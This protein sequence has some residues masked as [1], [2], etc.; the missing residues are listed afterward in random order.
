MALPGGAT[1]ASAKNIGPDLPKPLP[2]YG[3]VFPACI[4][5]ISTAAHALRFERE[6][7]AERDALLP[8]CA[9]DAIAGVAVYAVSPGLD[10]QSHQRLVVR[11]ALVP[12]PRV[13]QKVGP[14]HL[15][16]ASVERRHHRLDAVDPTGQRPEQV[17]LV[18]VIDPDVWVLQSRRSSARRT[19]PGHALRRTPRRASNSKPWRKAAAAQGRRG[20]GSLG[21]HTSRGWGQ[22][23]HPITVF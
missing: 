18:A 7:L 10:H 8:P 13:P 3:D 23:H 5:P 15:H 12:G 4:I 21:P 17:E 6:P 22:M 9:V 16:P 20:S 19:A 14:E 2:T 1:R 11:L